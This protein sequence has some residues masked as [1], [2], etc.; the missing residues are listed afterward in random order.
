MLFRSSRLVV[1]MCAMVAVP[2]F[3]QDEPDDDE[4]T[5]EHTWAP[6]QQ[7]RFEVS[8][9]TWMDLDVSPDGQTIVFDLLGDIYTMPVA[10]GSATRISGGPAFD[11][12]PRFSPDGTRIAFVS[13]RDGLNNIWTMDADGADPEQVSSE[14]ERDVNTPSWS[15]DGEYIFARKHFVFSRSLGAGEIWMWHRTGGSGLQVT[16]R[17]NEQQDQGEPAASPDG[18]WLYYSQ[19]VT[20][21]PLFQYNKD[22]YRG[23][24][25]IRRRNLDTGEQETVTGGF[26]GAIAPTPHPDGRRLAFVRRVRENTV[27]YMRDLDTFEEWPVWDGLERDMQEAWAIHGP[28]ARFAWVGDSD[29]IVLWAKGKIWRLDTSTG[30]ASE[31]PFTAQVDVRVQQ[32]VRTQV[33]VAPPKQRLQGRGSDPQQRAEGPAARLRLHPPSGELGPERPGGR[34]VPRTLVRRVGYEHRQGT[35]VPDDDGQLNHLVE[36]QRFVRQR[37]HGVIAENRAVR[38]PLGDAL[39]PRDHDQPT[40]SLATRG[41][42]EEWGDVTTV[43]EARRSAPEGRPLA[44]DAHRPQR[45]PLDKALSLRAA[46][47]A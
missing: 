42:P 5:V 41:A 44:I 24:Y 19:D 45:V 13:D 35:C 11:F 2:A 23:I 8:E 47:Q 33:D 15:P 38:E 14:S 22:P 36:A 39:G 46:A 10:G 1:M 32:A 28:Q 34:T 6:T 21:G 12:Q 30:Q 43:R 4:W 26:G 40:G 37:E 18:E 3:A 16:D 7:A 20:Q 29:D 31:I 27:L 9:G 25:A 17:P